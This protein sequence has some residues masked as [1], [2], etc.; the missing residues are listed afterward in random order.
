MKPNLLVPIVSRTNYS[1]L[2][3]IVRK[4]NER[5]DI[6]TSVLLSSGIV[7]RKL[8]DGAKDIYEDG[9]EVLHELDCL[10]MNDTLES[11][12]KSLG[13]SLIDHATVFSKSKPNGL[14][15]VGDRYDMLGPVITAMMMN[16]PIFHIQGGEISG[17]VD[18]IVR[19]IIT[20]CAIRHYTSTIKSTEKVKR[21]VGENGV[22]HTG[23]PAVEFLMRL[24]ISNELRVEKFHKHFKDDIS[25]K[26]GE[27]YFII[28]VHPDTTDPHDI[29][30]NCLLDAALSFK[31]TCIVLHPNIDAYRENI[32][33]AI[34]QHRNK[35]I[36]ISHAPLEDFVQLMAHSVCVIGNSSAGIREAASFKVPVVNV[37]QRQQGRERNNN[38]FDVICDYDEIKNAISRALLS[39]FSGENIYYKEGAI[40]FISQDIVDYLLNR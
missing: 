2:R 13:V 20:R 4:L 6:R 1:K 15:V 9:L 3:P 36:C 39:R 26:P 32:S 37:G 30:M 23:C 35:I 19:D 27:P 18:D 34:R 28:I 11:M 25:L 31:Y 38:T 10:L 14:L 5:T 17:T 29:D 12:V 24:P 40:D 8:T 33:K 22:F 7:L 21:L 16:I